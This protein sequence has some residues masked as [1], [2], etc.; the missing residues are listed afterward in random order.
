MGGDKR[1]T[2]TLRR[3]LMNNYKRPFDP[4]PKL[5][6]KSYIIYEIKPNPEENSLV[7]SFNSKN[8]QEVASLTK[9][10]TC[11]VTL[12]LCQKFN[13]NRLAEEV[14]IGNMEAN[15]GGTTANL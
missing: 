6:A 13:V 14:E 15:L 2:V 12:E 4:P 10:M 7:F 8:S 1:I 11:L 3:E 5:T 9:I